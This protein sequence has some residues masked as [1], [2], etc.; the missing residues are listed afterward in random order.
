MVTL[1]QRQQPATVTSATGRTVAYDLGTMSD[2][3]RASWM[4]VYE[5]GMQAGWQMG[6]D[7]AEADLSAIQRR[8]HATVQDVARGLPYDVLCERRGER[9]RAER[10][11]QTLK[12]RGVA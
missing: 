2:D 9:H 10:Q 12:E 3:A 8:A 4:A 1:E 11:R 5:L 6:Y 7:A